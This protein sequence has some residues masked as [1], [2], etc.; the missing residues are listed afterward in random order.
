MDTEAIRTVCES[1]DR[2]I[3]V[4]DATVN[5]M[6]DAMN[7]VSEK[8]VL[9]HAAIMGN[10]QTPHVPGLIPQVDA[11]R[12]Q[13]LAANT[14]IAEMRQQI[15]ETTRNLEAY[16]LSMPPAA[17]LKAEQSR[18]TMWAGRIGGAGFVLACLWKLVEYLTSLKK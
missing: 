16:K 7:A 2:R 13:I 3:T 1:L 17:E 5:R 8:L 14:A 6:E 10:M 4:A 12:V 11:I 18:M 15:S 9:I